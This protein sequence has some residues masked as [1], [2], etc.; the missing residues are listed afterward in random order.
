MIN[1]RGGCIPDFATTASQTE[2][3]VPVFLPYIFTEVAGTRLTHS[4]TSQMFRLC[5]MNRNAPNKNSEEESLA[6]DEKKHK[7]G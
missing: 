5:A 1:V 7:K 4:A 3:S 6:A 2:M